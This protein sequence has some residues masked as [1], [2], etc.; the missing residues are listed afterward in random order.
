MELFGMLFGLVFWSVV[1]LVWLAICANRKLPRQTRRIGLTCIA[2]LPT[3]GAISIA[4]WMFI[5]EPLRDAAANG[6]A[7]RVKH[8][9]AVGANPNVESEGSSA[10]SGGAY[11]GNLETVRL[12]LAHGADPNRTSNFE[13]QTPLQLAQERKHTEIVVLLQK[14]GATK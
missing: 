5:D 6:D 3:I 8:L 9:L 4:H 7:P 13:P 12:L 10:L 11:N 1:I 14:A 2:L